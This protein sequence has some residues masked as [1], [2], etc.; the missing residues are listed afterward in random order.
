MATQRFQPLNRGAARSATPR[1]SA[2]PH[3]V[4]G[5]LSLFLFA[6]C[7]T[8]HDPSGPV[9]ARQAARDEQIRELRENIRTLSSMKEEYDHR[10]SDDVLKKPIQSALDTYAERIGRLEKRMDEIEGR[11]AGLETSV[12]SNRTAWEKKMDTVLDVVK[13]ENAQLREAIDGL[14]KSGAS[15]G[16]EHTVAPGETLAGIAAEYGARLK[17][18]IEVNEIENPH[19]IRIGQK[20]FIPRPGR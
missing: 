3:A 8:S 12:N 19:K 16:W 18:I 20:L 13:K 7:A 15:M 6:G 1:R 4:C 10:L 5:L 17:E 11:L 9:L 2:F 14:Q